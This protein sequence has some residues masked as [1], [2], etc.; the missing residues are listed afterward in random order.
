MGT[1]RPRHNVY[2]PPSIPP[3]NSRCSGGR[4]KNP[5]PQLGTIIG[6]PKRSLRWIQ[7]A[8]AQA[9][10]RRAPAHAHAD[11]RWLATWLF[12]SHTTTKRSAVP[13]TGH[14]RT[15]RAATNS[16]AHTPPGFTPGGAT[17][18]TA[19]GTGGTAATGA[20]GATGGATGAT[21]TNDRSCSS[22]APRA[23]SI[24]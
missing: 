13:N 17:G 18:G 6:K 14:R 2:Q 9:R 5:R 21:G 1:H 8:R 19:A 3:P 16:A 20:T 10:A 4:S 12:T 15:N 7:R 11:Q 24:S 23:N 22:V